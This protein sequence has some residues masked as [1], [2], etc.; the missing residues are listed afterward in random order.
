MSAITPVTI[1]GVPSLA[2]LEYTSGL[3]G[4]A[5]NG[6]LTPFV[7]IL[8]DSA[9]GVQT[10]AS[11]YATQIQTAVQNLLELARDGLTPDSNFGGYQS[12][13]VS[14]GPP[15]VYK[16]TPAGDANYLSVEL[17]TN[18]DLLIKSLQSAG[19]TINFPSLILT[20]VVSGGGPPV[21]TWSFGTTTSITPTVTTTS[22]VGATITAT[23]YNIFYPA[24]NGNLVP[25][26]TNLAN[27]FGTTANISTL[28][29]GGTPPPIT[30]SFG[31]GNAAVLKWKDLA[32]Q[33]PTI[34]NILAAGTQEST[35][36]N[37]TLQALV[38]LVY[39][40][41]GNQVIAGALQ[42]LD[43]AL[44]TTQ[45][46]LDTLNT[47]QQIHNNITTAAKPP[48][49]NT[50]N[51]FP[52]TTG[53]PTTFYS[54]YQ[55]AASA[56]FNTPVDP[57]LPASFSATSSDFKKAESQ[58]ISMREQLRTQIS[59]LSRTT[60]PILVSGQP[61]EDASSLLGKIRKVYDDLNAN[62][63]VGGN[64]VTFTSDPTQAFNAFKTWVLDSY[65]SSASDPSKSGLLQQNITNAI[66]A[67]QNLNDTQK[68][69][70]RRYLF[71]F[72]EYYKSASAVLAQITEII[73]KIAQNIA[74]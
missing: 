12:Q 5:Y 69:A 34:Q 51:L 26:M 28:V 31:T 44:T 27:A 66:A 15:P 6:L 7:N 30:V 48:F 20:H 19:A 39:V 2:Q 61:V 43:E 55:H 18:L 56:F 23:R 57:T 8:N 16:L 68:E 41:T 65:A 10:N 1:N 53:S 25:S 13:Q 50:F 45:K 67:G 4:N 9:S 33:S 14:V 17:A 47:I 74:R 24:A 63:Q 40:K 64:P 70:V 21:D 72:E 22:I 38:E 54:N 37:R 36:G 73:T 58:L 49:G 42:S 62:F 71:V 59:T 3:V 11:S 60:P 46:V 52:G 29:P 35:I 32:S